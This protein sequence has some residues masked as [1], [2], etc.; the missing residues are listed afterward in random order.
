MAPVVKALQ[1][2]PGIT[3][4]V[5]VTGQHR[6]MLDPVLEAFQIVPDRDLAL[7]GRVAGLNGLA[8]GAIYALDEV[9]HAEQPDRVLVHGDTT[10]ALAGALAAFHRRVPVAH[11]EAGLRTGD[12]ARPWPE[13][14]NRRCIDAMADWLFPPTLAADEALLAEGLGNRQ[15]LVTGNTVIDAL[16]LAERALARGIAADEV[17]RLDERLS[18]GRRVVLVTGHRRESFGAG[19][20]GICEALSR[21]SMRS[22]IEIVYPVHLNPQVQAPVNERLG[23]RPRVHLIPPLNYL[24]FVW[25]MRRADVILTDSGGVQEEAPALGTP[26]LVMREVTERPEA[27]SAGAAQL[28]G[29]DPDRIEAAVLSVLGQRAAASRAQTPT[30]MAARRSV[31]SVHS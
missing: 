5:C 9:I 16:S 15:R 20:R 24:P 14:M 17:S 6:Q 11:V 30:V 27:V 1:A 22:D 26:V 3:S 8:A 29:T 13:E 12:L 7:M 18:S 25:L 19:F 21:L 4:R 2:E 31:S 10:T 28:V 23:G